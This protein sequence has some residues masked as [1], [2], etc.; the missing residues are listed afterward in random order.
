MTPRQFRRFMRRYEAQVEAEANGQPI[1]AETAAHMT[2]PAE[3]AVYQVYVICNG[4]PMPVGFKAEK[5]IVED[6]AASI[7]ALIKSGHEKTWSEPLV[8]RV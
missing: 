1:D 2:A 7:R 5:S 6:F 3:R 8:V 4:K